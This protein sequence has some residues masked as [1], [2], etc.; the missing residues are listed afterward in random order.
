MSIVGALFQQGEGPSR[1]LPSLGTVN[2]REGTLTAQDITASF[3][4]ICPCYNAG[5]P[6]S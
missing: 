5:K 3:C 2:L 6:G 4:H 1:G